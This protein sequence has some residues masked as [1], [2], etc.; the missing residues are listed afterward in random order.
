[1][2]RM[3]LERGRFEQPLSF[4]GPLAVLASE[5]LLLALP[6]GYSDVLVTVEEQL[7]YQSHLRRAWQF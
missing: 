6:R 2:E 5:N 7:E 1:M 3:A 4:I